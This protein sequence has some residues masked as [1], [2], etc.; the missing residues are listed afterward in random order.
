MRKK[1]KFIDIIEH[2]TFNWDD[3][4][5]RELLRSM[6]MTACDVAAMTKPWEIQKEVAMLVA[7]EFFEQGDRERD[8]LQLEPMAMMDRQ[9]K[10]ELPKMQVGF[11]DAICAPLYKELFELHPPLQ[12]LYDGVMNNSSYWQE[13]GNKPKKDPSCSSITSESANTQE[14]EREKGSHK[15]RTVHSNSCHRPIEAWRSSHNRKNSSEMGNSGGQVDSTAAT[16]TEVPAGVS[17]RQRSK[18]CSVM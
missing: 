18:R 15:L 13:L 17:S 3:V 6:L 10:D 1:G 4:N 7:G 11:I 5:H 9:K 8:E 16:S 2:H 14:Q 12:P